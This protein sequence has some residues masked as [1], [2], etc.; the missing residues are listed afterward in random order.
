[1]WHCLKD[2]DDEW[3]TSSWEGTTNKAH[4]SRRDNS[5]IFL[6]FLFLTNIWHY[7]FASGNKPSSVQTERKLLA[8]FSN[9]GNAI[10][11]NMICRSFRELP[12]SSS[13]KTCNNSR[14]HKRRE[15]CKNQI[16]LDGSQ[17]RLNQTVKLN[18]HS[19]T[20]C[21][22]N[23]KMKNVTCSALKTWRGHLEC[24]L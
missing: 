5:I 15:N 21:L 14:S 12:Q 2:V 3:Y 1:M 7:A 10:T 13:G 11:S 22:R 6:G 17:L 18:S 20:G 8:M 9:A 24:R 19:H 16:E 4:L 23:L